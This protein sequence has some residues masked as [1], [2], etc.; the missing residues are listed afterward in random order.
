MRPRRVVLV[1]TTLFAAVAT[2][3]GAQSIA[4]GQ[5]RN[6]IIRQQVRVAIGDSGTHFVTEQETSWRIATRDTL[7]L[8]VDSTLRVVRVA[9]DGQRTTSWGR[10]GAK[11][12]IPHTRSPGDMLVTRV[13]FHGALNVHSW[14]ALPRDAPDSAPLV[15]TVEVPAGSQPVTE[16]AADQVDTL[17]YARTNWRFRFAAPVALRTL[18]LT[19]APASR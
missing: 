14:F 8:L 5:P 10:T 18:R 1:A 15:L 6:E 2:A 9:L 12:V 7:V 11:L 4:G 3:V 17:A 19:V 16:T 13:R